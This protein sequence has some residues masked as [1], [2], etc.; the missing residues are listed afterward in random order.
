MPRSFDSNQAYDALTTMVLAIHDDAALSNWFERLACLSSVERRNE[1][2][3]LRS[4]MQLEPE[5]AT[6][7]LSLL[8]DDRVFRAAQQ[9]YRS[10]SA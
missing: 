1:I 2:Y 4:E 9:A 3:R 10:L 5:S 8:S 6:V 7:P